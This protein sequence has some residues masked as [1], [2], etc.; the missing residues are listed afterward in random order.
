MI[1][2]SIITTS[3][4][5]VSFLPGCIESVQKSITDSSFEI[6]QIIIDDAST[7]NT[8]T[9]LTKS[10]H[11]NIKLLR[12]EK[13]LGPAASRN[14]AMRSS[15]A[16]YFYILDADDILIQNSIR[17]LVEQTQ[18]G[19]IAWVYGD[20]IT[21]DK[22]LSY[23]LGKDFYGRS[24]ESTEEVLYALFTNQHFFQQTSLFSR[25][26]FQQ[27]GGYK[28]NLITGEDVDLFIR[29][30][31]AGVVPKFAPIT[32]H[33]R[34]IHQNNLSGP[35]LKNHNRYFQDLKRYF[36][37]YS[38]EILK[39]LSSGHKNEVLEFINELGKSSTGTEIR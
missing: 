30:I 13:K 29:F 3:L 23:I 4:N 35:Y 8:Q 11:G 34:R 17:Y 24:F 39:Q 37:N 33:L 16:D 19:K 25:K 9:Q 22:N 21:V 2:V 6:E 10:K 1:K 28:E 12:N 7:D 15:D 31:L 18:H 38:E 26:L 36:D 14:K 5:S 27:V 20:H 32:T